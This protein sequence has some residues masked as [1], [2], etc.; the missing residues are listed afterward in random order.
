MHNPRGDAIER[1]SGPYSSLDAARSRGSNSHVDVVGS[2]LRLRLLMLL[3]TGRSWSFCLN[4]EFTEFTQSIC[5]Y[6]DNDKS[7][8]DGV[9]I[10]NPVMSIDIRD[11]LLF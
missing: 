11:S 2:I 1:R 6:P 7:T 9:L 8:R 3:G 5:V 4:W 10:V